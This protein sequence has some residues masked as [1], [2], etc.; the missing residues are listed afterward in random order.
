MQVSVQGDYGAKVVALLR[1]LI[2][3]KENE[4]EIKSL[5]RQ[6]H[7]WDFINPRLPYIHMRK[8][9]K[10]LTVASWGFKT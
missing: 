7:L 2:W 3:L 6:W 8:H 10:Q 9:A 4:P 5:V 1:R